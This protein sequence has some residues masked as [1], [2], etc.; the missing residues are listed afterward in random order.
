MKSSSIRRNPR[1][2]CRSSVLNFSSQFLLISALPFFEGFC[3]NRKLL[4]SYINF[5]TDT[6]LLQG[7]FQCVLCK[8]IINPLMFTLPTI[9]PS[10]H[11]LRILFLAVSHVPSGRSAPFGLA[12][13]FLNLQNLSAVSSQFRTETV[14]LSCFH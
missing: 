9:K 4:L 3:Q 11:R 7:S 5:I 8:I 13:S 12:P 6:L 2:R 1:R 10:A 14:S